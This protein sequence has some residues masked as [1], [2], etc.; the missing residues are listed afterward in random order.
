MNKKT[1]IVSAPVFFIH[2]NDPTVIKYL[3]QD[4]AEKDIENW[5]GII[6][7]TFNH[8]LEPREGYILYKFDNNRGY[9]LDIDNFNKYHTVYK[10][11][12][13]KRELPSDYPNR[14]KKHDC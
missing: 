9:Y 1:I 12:I 14:N 3:P 11:P 8:V 4:V 10:K 7:Q 13:D 6:V 5:K 2:K